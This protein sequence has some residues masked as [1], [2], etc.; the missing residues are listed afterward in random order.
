MLINELSKRT[1]VSIPTLRY[2]ENYGLFQGLKDEK[3]KTN[4]YKDY[5][6]SIV[7]KMEMIKGAKEAG[8]TL[9]E[10][11]KLLD[12]WYNKR[13]SVDKKVE[14]V[15]DKIKEIDGKIRQ[16]KA[17]KKILLVCIDDIEQG[18]C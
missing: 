10:I 16:L 13:L 9:S 12:S 2:Y 8:F 14:I 11:K 17:V 18:D 3:V 7:E 6:E 15:H 4:N 5:D 1:G